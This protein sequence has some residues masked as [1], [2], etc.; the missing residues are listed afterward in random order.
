MTDEEIRD[1]IDTAINEHF[2]GYSSESG[3]MMTS[4]GGDGR[5]FGKVFA[6]RYSGLPPSPFV[7]LAIGKSEKGAQI[8]KFGRSECIAP[9][10]HDLDM[11]L[12]KELGIDPKES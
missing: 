5:F 12:Q 11:I 10:Q 3:E 2:K 7:F 1:Y 6:T 4:E 9:T 8:M